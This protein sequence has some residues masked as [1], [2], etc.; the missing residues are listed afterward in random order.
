MKNKEQLRKD[1]SQLSF[2]I[3]EILTLI[4]IL[5]VA[6]EYNDDC[7]GSNEDL[8]YIPT[9][10]KIIEKQMKNIPEKLDSLSLELSDIKLK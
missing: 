4:K 7:Q 8:L 6:L 10:A 3:W 2:E 9:L 1:I 5:V